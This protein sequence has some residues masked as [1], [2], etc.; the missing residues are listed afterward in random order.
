MMLALALALYA[1]TSAG[2]AARPP[3]VALSDDPPIQVWL[4]SDSSFVRG[5]RARVY[6]R[7]AQDGYIL[8]LHADAE[9]RVRV[10]FPI[11]PGDDA[12]VDGEKDFEVL[13]RGDREAIT[14]GDDG[15]GT[16]LVAWSATPFVFDGLVR[17]DHWDLGAVGTLDKSDDVEAGLVKIVQGTAVDGHFDYDVT[18]YTVRSTTA[19]NDGDGG[20][21]GASVEPTHSGSTVSVWFGAPWP[22]WYTGVGP[23]CG[24]YYWSSWGCGPYYG[25]YY[26]V[27][28]RPYWYRPYGYSHYYGSRPYGYGRYGYGRYGNGGYGYPAYRSRLAG[29]VGVVG[30]FRHEPVRGTYAFRSAGSRSAGS[31]SAGSRSAGSWNG[32][33]S[34][35]R[36]STEGRRVAIASRVFARERSG[37]RVSAPGS[38]TYR[39]GGYA[40]P[41]S[42][43]RSSAAPR[44]ERSGRSAPA[45][46]GAPSSG[47]RR[48]GWSDAAPR[49]SGG[50][51]GAAPRGE[52][53]GRSAPAARSAPSGGSRRGGWSDAAPRS[54]GGGGGYSRGGGGGGREGGGGYSR[55]GGG[56]GGGGGGRHEGGGGGGGSRRR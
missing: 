9:G 34:G 51:S 35:I 53:S 2:P 38:R 31:R 50:R 26:S 27:A 40:R 37:L 15:T 3:A 1:S 21:V 33:R 46:R 19:Y 13:D 56:G 39:D 45:A 28:Y 29:S 17:D 18:T 52:R 43:G 32:S 44:G 24:S 7:A 47:S 54:S 20:D 42:G 36:V 41:S 49:S 6:V 22:Y 10:L 8:V 25:P 12:F 4:S 5:E 55:G 16:V 23:F 48:G 14:A 30:G 11:E